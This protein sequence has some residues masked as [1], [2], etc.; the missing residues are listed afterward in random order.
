MACTHT[1]KWWKEMTPCG[2]CGKMYSDEEADSITAAAD[3]IFGRTLTP[4]QQAIIDRLS[5]EKIKE[6]EEREEA[7][8]SGPFGAGA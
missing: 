3:A 7:A 2:S 6:E 5:A 1:S 8:A 4:K